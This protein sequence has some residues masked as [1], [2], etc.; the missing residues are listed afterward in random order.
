MARDPENREVIQSV[1][2][3]FAGQGKESGVKKD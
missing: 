2:K 3:R 1:A